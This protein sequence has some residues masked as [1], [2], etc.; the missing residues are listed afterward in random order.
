[1]ESG[2]FDLIPSKYEPIRTFSDLGMIFY[3]RIGDKDI[4]L[5]FEIDSNMPKVLYGD[6]LRIRQLIINIV[7]NAIKYTERGIVSMVLKIAETSEDSIE[8]HVTVSDTGKGIKKED[9][10]YL[11]DA[12]Q[13]VDESNNAT[14]E[15][16]GLGLSI[17]KQ[18]VELMDGKINV[19]S[20]YGK[21]S[22]FAFTVKQSLVKE[23]KEKVYQ[24]Q[25]NGKEQRVSC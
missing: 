23:G 15:G 24:I 16:T 19:E 14:I 17:S 8:F 6:A 2:K 20:E 1:M 9:I 3:T 12:Y 4:E 25:S 7:N 11:F 22:K 5:L 10:P 18:L 21:G 13:R